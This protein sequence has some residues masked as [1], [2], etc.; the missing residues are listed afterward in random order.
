MSWVKRKEG[1]RGLDSLWA[2]LFLTQYQM[3]N[4]VLRLIRLALFKKAR[5]NPKRI[6]LLRQGGFGDTISAL[7]SI[8]CIRKIFPSATIDLLAH[9]PEL[10][11]VP[12][13]DIVPSGTF[14]NIYLY[15]HFVDKDIRKQL[16]ANKYDLY[17]ELPSYEASLFFELRSMLLAKKLGIPG[18]IGWQVSSMPFSGKKQEAVLEFDSDRTRLLKILV[19]YKVIKEEEMPASVK[20]AEDGLREKTNRIM[21][22]IGTNAIGLIIGAGKE[23]NIWPY[24]KPVA[25]YYTKKGYNVLLLGGKQD[26]GRGEE[27]ATIAGVV[28]L[29]GKLSWEE[30]GAVLRECDLV[31]SNDTGPIHLAY[32]LG[33]PV[34]G[35]YSGLDYSNRWF[36]PKEAK[37]SVLRNNN[38]PCIICYK[39]ECHDNICLKSIS[40]FNVIA[41]ADRLLAANGE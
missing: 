22:E 28:N 24:F 34:L 4:Q 6:L 36:P 31:I 9:P 17:I 27:I 26:T 5:Q 23:R 7:P 25:D 16:K 19:K 21:P 32:S 15:N 37:N 18:G 11:T 33:T 1:L 2:G 10:E 14:G 8:L 20:K 30:T 3:Q 41:E 12:I 13:S 38:V 39:K 40:V 29:C 35:I